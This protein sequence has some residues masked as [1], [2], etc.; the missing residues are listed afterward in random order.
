M[1][2][3]DLGKGERRVSPDARLSAYANQHMFVSGWLGR[4]PALRQYLAWRRGDRRQDG[5]HDAQDPR[6][7]H[8]K[9]EAEY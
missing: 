2:N 4:S 1:S 6:T 5:Q 3:A 7:A 9:L 8:G